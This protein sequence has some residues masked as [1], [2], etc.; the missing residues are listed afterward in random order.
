MPADVE[1][2]NNIAPGMGILTQLDKIMIKQKW[3]FFEALTSD[4]LEFRNKYEVMD[5]NGNM[6]FFA[7]EES[8]CCMRFCCGRHRAFRMVFHDKDNKP[9]LT[10]IRKLKFCCAC[11]PC[12]LQEMAVFPG[13]AEEYDAPGK[14]GEITQPQWGGC[15]HPTLHLKDGNGNVEV[16]MKGPFIRND[17]C[18]NVPFQVLGNDGA[19]EIG[20]VVKVKPNGCSGLAR[21]AF[22]DAD[23][24]NVDFP[25]DLKVETKATILGAMMLIDFM[26]FE[27]NQKGCSCVICSSF[28]CG[29][30]C[31]IICCGEGFVDLNI[32]GC[33][34]P[35][36]GGDGGGPPKAEEMDR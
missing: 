6:V 24:F 21:E 26:F 14:I 9:V 29:A 25:K 7:G 22:T 2:A 10:M 28:F 16:T 4:L 15:F 35:I 12:C 3:H 19:T 27:D 13:A 30:P 17:C 5:E 33:Y 32:C 18:C 36:K 8:G 1:A 34:I 23:N 31:E 20:N 11:F